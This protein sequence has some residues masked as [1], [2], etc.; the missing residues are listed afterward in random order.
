MYWKLG[1][2][3]IYDHHWY[4]YIYIY[5]YLIYDYTNQI[6]ILIT[7]IN[8][9]IS[10]RYCGD[11]HWPLLTIIIHLWCKTYRVRLYIVLHKYYTYI[12]ICMYIHHHHH[13]HPNSSQNAVLNQPPPPSTAPRSSPSRHQ[14]QH[15]RALVPLPRRCGPWA[16]LLRRWW[17]WRR[18]DIRATRIGGSSIMGIHGDS[19]VYT[20]IIY[21]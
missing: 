17:S 1:T 3:L 10:T 2:L 7:R 14:P 13:H 15:R 8:S 11:H 12:Y 9:N 20:W 4:I 21:G 16:V 18:L 5:T 6:Q 19:M